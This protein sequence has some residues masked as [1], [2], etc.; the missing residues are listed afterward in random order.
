MNDSFDAR[1]WNMSEEW[2]KAAADIRNRIT[3]ARAEGG[4]TAWFNLSW[5]LADRF[6]FQFNAEENS[7]LAKNL[8]EA[9]S[10]LNVPG[11]NYGAK[12]LAANRERLENV[13]SSFDRNFWTF[14]NRYERIFAKHEKKTWLEE[15]EDDF[16]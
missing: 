11:N 3:V 9:R 13:L 16:K 10:L 5:D 6:F 7:E 14:L 15:I 1:P 12:L 2:L 8:R 4:L